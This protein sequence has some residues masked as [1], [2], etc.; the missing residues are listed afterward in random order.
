MAVRE[1]FYPDYIEEYGLMQE[2]PG[3]FIE[4]STKAGVK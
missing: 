1:A 4:F 3:E 2:L